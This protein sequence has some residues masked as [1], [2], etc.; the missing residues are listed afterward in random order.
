MIVEQSREYQSYE[1]SRRS[2]LRDGQV[3]E[4]ERWAFLARTIAKPS[5]CAGPKG[6]KIREYQAVWDGGVND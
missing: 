3:F 1:G 5:S 2:F 6:K 4:G